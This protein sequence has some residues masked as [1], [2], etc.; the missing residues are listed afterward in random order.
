MLQRRSYVSRSV[1]ALCL[2]ALALASSITGKR[3]RFDLCIGGQALGQVIGG[4]LAGAARFGPQ[5]GAQ[6]RGR[7][8]VEQRAMVALEIAHRLCHSA[9]K[10]RLRNWLLL[11]PAT[12]TTRAAGTQ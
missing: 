9:V 7:G 1:H 6:Q 4:L 3:H 11:A 5:A 12:W 2:V 8:P 10:E